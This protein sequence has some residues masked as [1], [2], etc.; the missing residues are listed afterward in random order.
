[1]RGHIKDFTLGLDRKQYITLALDGE[2]RP[3]YEKYKE[4]ADLDIDIKKHREKR[5]LDANAFLWVLLDKIADVILSDKEAIYLDMLE[6]YGV[7]TH[8][9][10]KPGAVE[11][12]K[13]QY[14]LCKD[15]GEIT[16]NGTTGNQIQCYFGSSSYDTKQMSRL[17]DGIVSECKELDIETY[18]PEQLD[19][20]KSE[21][22]H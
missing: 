22:G 11:A 14:R 10:V 2:N 9:I 4:A 18:T 20:M 21:W 13:A 6:K 16:V 8:I 5:S 15:L 19:L 17:I 7:F 12:F 3:T 1:M